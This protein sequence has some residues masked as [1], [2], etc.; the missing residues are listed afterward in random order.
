M[1]TQ[2][3]EGSGEIEVLELEELNHQNGAPIDL[4]KKLLT[5]YLIDFDLVNAKFLW[6]RIPND[7]KTDEELATIW[8]IGQSFWKREFTEAYSVISSYEWSDNH[9]ESSQKLYSILQNRMVELVAKA[10]SIIKF[11]ALAN[12]L[13][14][15]DEAT[16]LE[17]VN[18]KQWEVDQENKLVKISK[19]LDERLSDVKNQDQP[20]PQTLHRLTNYVS[21]L[22]N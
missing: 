19:H 3:N 12:L 17:L 4:Y 11:D 8:K 9:K 10:Y 6:K 22:E 1:E 13:G 16:L 21:F 7:L 2:K 20:L 18:N 14:I 5:L 15:N